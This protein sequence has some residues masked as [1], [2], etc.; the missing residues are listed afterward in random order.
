MNPRIPDQTYLDAVGDE[1]TSPAGVADTIKRST[2]AARYRLGQL[3]M[4]GKLHRIKN[5][6]QFCGRRSYLYKVKK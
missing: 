6:E 1:W 5:P 2:S 4:Q 3:Y